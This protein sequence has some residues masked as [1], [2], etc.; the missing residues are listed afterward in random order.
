LPDE[1]LETEPPPPEES[2]LL[3]EYRKETVKQAD[4][5]DDLAKELF[6]I[7]IAIPGLYA[8]ALKFFS[9]KGGIFSHWITAAF[10]CWAAA[11][12]I[13]LWGLIPK[14][15]DVLDDTAERVRESPFQEGLTIREYFSA[16]AG[17]KRRHLI[18][19]SVFFFAGIFLAGMSVIP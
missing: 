4:R 3:G 16:V 15:Y 9:D 6:K 10:V 1:I 2:F 12:G 13:T 17:H 18:W 8:T 7:E 5:M 19:A 11:L 14:K